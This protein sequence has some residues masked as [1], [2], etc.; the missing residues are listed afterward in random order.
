M[1]YRN[2]GQGHFPATSAGL[3]RQTSGTQPAS[4][5][6]CYSQLVPSHT[7]SI[8][9]SRISWGFPYLQ[10]VCVY[11]ALGTGPSHWFSWQNLTAAHMVLWFFGVDWAHCKEAEPLLHHCTAKPLRN[12]RVHPWG[13][14][15]QSRVPSSWSLSLVTSTSKMICASKLNIM[16][17]FL[18]INI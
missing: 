13:H 16:K 4:C 14:L 7:N 15:F 17:K 8:S 18:K 3:P 6:I 11:N 2:S 1:P 10:N 12:F 5:E 9:K